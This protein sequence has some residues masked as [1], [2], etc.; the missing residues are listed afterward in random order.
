MWLIVSVETFRVLW[1]GFWP[2]T[3]VVMWT[4]MERFISETRVVTLLKRN[5]CITAKKFGVCFSTRRKTKYTLITKQQHWAEEARHDFSGWQTQP[6]SFSTPQGIMT[7]SWGGGLFLNP[8]GNGDIQTVCYYLQSWSEPR[9]LTTHSP[10][11]THS[12]V[13]T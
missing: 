13:S 9:Y 1:S 4:L 6:P 10:A 8:N 11:L 3:C 12:P 5:C 7:N 2:I